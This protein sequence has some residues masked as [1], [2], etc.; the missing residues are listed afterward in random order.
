M[1]DERLLDLLRNALRAERDGYEF[2]TAAAGRSADD[3]ARELFSHLAEEER[4]H[5]D[6]LQREYR[7]ILDGSRWDEQV[8]LGEPWSPQTASGVFSERFRDRIGE[9]HLEMSALSIGILLEEDAERFYRAA[10]KAETD[11]AIRGFLL[12]LADWELGH[13]RMLTREDEAMRDAYWQASRFA[14]LL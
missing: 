12:E 8:R 6:A 1:G 2:Y 3:G 9:R 7:A 10:A 5:Y 13:L 11:A 14:P 4:R